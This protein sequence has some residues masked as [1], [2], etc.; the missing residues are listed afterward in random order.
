MR[1]II[2]VCEQASAYD[3]FDTELDRQADAARSE[4]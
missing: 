3:D 4:V 1:A 2:T